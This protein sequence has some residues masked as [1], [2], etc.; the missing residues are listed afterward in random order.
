MEK[1]LQRDE[2]NKIVA[3]VAAGLADYLDIDVVWVRLAFVL[4][5]L[6]G[7]SGVLIYLILWIVVPARPYFIPYQGTPGGQADE[8]SPISKSRSD[9]PKKLVGAVLIV[10][11]LYFLLNEFFTVP[12][13]L[14]F[15]KFWPVFFI[16]G[17]LFII[18]S[19]AKK[20]SQPYEDLPGGEE[21]EAVINDDSRKTENEN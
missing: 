13:W 10:F 21:G 12:I 1:K 11:G 7:F 17:G 2:S 15:T 16:I 14:H 9:R 5:V 19:A 3:G 4:A 6:L 8:P 18:F 20:K